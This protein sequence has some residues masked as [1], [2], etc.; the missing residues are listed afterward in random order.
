[1]ASHALSQMLD[2]L[3]GRDRNLAATE[4]KSELHWQDPEV[5]K[6]FLVD[7]CPHELFVNT[8]ADLGPC[9][10][11]HDEIFKKEYKTSTRV[12]TMGFEEEFERY[13]EGLIADV[14]RRIRRGHQRLA[15]NNAQ[16]NLNGQMNKDKEEKVQMLTE[17]INDLVQQAEELGCEGKVEEA[18][19]VMK[20]CDQ[21]RE[22][23]KQSESNKLA[24]QSNEPE[25]TM[26]V[27]SVCG[28]LL[29]VGDVQQRIDEHLMGKQHAGYARIRAYVEGKK[30][31]RVNEEEEREARYQKEREDREKE[32]E[33]ERE[34][35]RQRE[36]ERE[37][38]E[39]EREREREKE[40]EKEREER[41]KKRS[42]SRDRD[43]HRRSRSRSRQK[44][45]SR[46]RSR[47]RHRSSRNRRSRSRSRSRKSRSRDRR[48]RD[49]DSRR[50]SRS[51]ERSRDKDRSS[52]DRSKRSRDR[53][54]RDKGKTKSRSRDRDGPVAQEKSKE[55]TSS[56][57]K[58][59]H[60]QNTVTEESKD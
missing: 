44:R 31:K 30:M 37:E 16:G 25:K 46:S 40:R 9:E 13:L 3:M 48:S 10:K 2:E 19:G 53:K 45:R 5:C 33:K 55:D 12:K 14:E 17:R 38:K 42:R 56:N 32:R 50:R 6:F 47:D 26:E 59:E 29:V 39:K 15:L 49:K 8:R 34:E 36:K 58:D 18:Q 11:I 54:D 22:E 43:R 20:L 21:L 27:C 51:K 28:A 60:A 41:R 52:R 1:M 23:R 57:R 35:R 4:R 24:T 7:F